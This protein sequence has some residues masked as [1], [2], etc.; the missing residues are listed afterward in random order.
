[1]NILHVIRHG[2]LSCSY[3]YHHHQHLHRH[4]H[5]HHLH[6][7]ETILLTLNVIYI[8]IINEVLLLLLMCTCFI[9]ELHISHTT[10]TH[11]I[12]YCTIVPWHQML[13]FMNM[14]LMRIHYSIQNMCRFQYFTEY[15]HYIHAIC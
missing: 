6:I 3:C 10:N 4:L 13:L 15:L 12:Q 2:I 9:C 1:M 14:N 5:R 8:Y 11:C 7:L